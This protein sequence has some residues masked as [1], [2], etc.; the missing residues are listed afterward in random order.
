[1]AIDALSELMSKLPAD[2]PAPILIAQHASSGN[3]AIFVQQVRIA[4]RCHH[5]ELHRCGDEA[6]WWTKLGLDP[7]A[8]A[9]ILWL[10]SH[11]LPRTS[12]MR[13]PALSPPVQTH[14]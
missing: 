11:P 1:M 3:A 9:R 14:Q 10:E 2:F 7:I 12:P 13:I 6:A 8:A 4:S 5:R